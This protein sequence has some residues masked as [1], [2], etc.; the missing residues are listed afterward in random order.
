MST[1]TAKIHICTADDPWSP[2]KA[3]R[4]R[5]NDAVPIGEQQDG[6]PSGDIQRYRCPHCE[7]EFDLELPQ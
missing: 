1:D 4:A 6:W 3:K 7:H 2:E 5:H